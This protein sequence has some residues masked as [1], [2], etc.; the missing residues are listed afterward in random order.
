MDPEWKPVPCKDWNWY[1]AVAE[2]KCPCGEEVIVDA[3][4]GIDDCVC[5]CGRKYVASFDVKISEPGPENSP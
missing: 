5:S 2:V 1:D 3:Q 4:N